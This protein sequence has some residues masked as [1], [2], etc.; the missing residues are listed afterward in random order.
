MAKIVSINQKI[1]DSCKRCLAQTDE[2]FLN[3]SFEERV[4]K[5]QDYLKAKEAIRDLM[6]RAQG[7]FAPHQDEEDI[8]EK[9]A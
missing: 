5:Y 2:L 3:M 9:K 6:R 7:N 1:I 4:E 8:N